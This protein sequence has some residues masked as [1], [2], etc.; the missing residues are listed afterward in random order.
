MAVH[1][2]DETLVFGLSS[3]T[4]VRGYEEWDHKVIKNNKTVLDLA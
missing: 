4:P 3:E 2:P 1:Q